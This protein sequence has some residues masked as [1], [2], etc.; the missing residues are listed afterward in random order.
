MNQQTAAFIS[1]STKDARREALIFLIHL[2]GDLHQPLHV[3]DFAAGG[4]D[5]KPVCF[6]NSCAQDNK[7]HHTWDN[8]IPNKIRGLKLR[9]SGKEEEAE[10]PSWADDLAAADRIDKQSLQADFP[11]TDPDKCSLK[12]A[13]ETNLLNCKHVLKKSQD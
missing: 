9:A 4:N 5:I 1:P 3:E 12:W 6:D 8:F 13:R 11:V 10:A 2:I 7:L